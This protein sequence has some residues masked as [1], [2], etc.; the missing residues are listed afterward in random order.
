MKDTTKVPAQYR[1]GDVMIE[2][3]E[4][5]PAGLKEVPRTAG[6]IILATGKGNGRAH[7]IEDAGSEMFSDADG[8]RFLAVKGAP[9]EGAELK[10][11]LPIL[12][13]SGERITVQ[14]P[15]QGRAVFL[16]TDVKMPARGGRKEITV[17]GAFAFLRHDCPQPDHNALAI[18]RGTYRNVRQREFSQGD[19]RNVID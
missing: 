12:S 2:R 7:V 19:I 16:K 5:L 11:R 10:H 6:K 18:P 3:V 15:Q 1:Q 9:V 17:A 4:Q 8:N 13:V 14:H